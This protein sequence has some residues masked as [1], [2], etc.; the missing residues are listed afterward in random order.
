MGTNTG[1]RSGRE[2]KDLTASTSH[3]AGRVGAVRA[4]VNP[5]GG[6]GANGWNMTSLDCVLREGSGRPTSA[7]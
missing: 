6:K 2:D 1:G 7:W 5:Q 4:L 3:G